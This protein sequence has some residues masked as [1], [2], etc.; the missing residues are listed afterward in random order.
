M[1]VLI[2]DDEP[3][4]LRFIIDSLHEQWCFCLL[5]STPEEARKLFSESDTLPD[6]VIL[7]IMMPEANPRA[8]DPEGHATGVQLIEP[9]VHYYRRIA[10]ANA[11]GY[12]TQH[13][14]VA[15]LTK[16]TDIEILSALDK[17]TA[18]TDGIRCKR[19]PKT[20]KPSVF[21]AEFLE[22]VKAKMGDGA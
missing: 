9:L 13:L 17:K 11:R 18:A 3:R 14:P 16:L 4:D 12:L 15:I 2:I 21:A 8:E 19:W 10:G 6:A 1:N 22:F 5:V 7:D 20:V